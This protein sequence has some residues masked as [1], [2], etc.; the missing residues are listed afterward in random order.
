MDGTHGEAAIARELGGGILQS[1]PK[2][3]LQGEPP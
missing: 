1:T 2:T 3:C